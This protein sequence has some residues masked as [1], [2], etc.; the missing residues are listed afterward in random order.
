MV[1]HGCCRKSWPEQRER[2]YYSMTEKEM[3]G[4]K[5]ER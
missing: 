1:C 5:S 4:E 2:E 3:E